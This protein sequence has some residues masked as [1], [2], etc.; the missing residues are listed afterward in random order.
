MSLKKTLL[1]ISALLFLLFIFFSFLVAKEKFTSLDFDTTVKIQDRLPRK[2]DLPFSYLS[3]IG[4]VEV[5]GLFMFGLLSFM[6]LKRY[7][8]TAA[9]LFLLPFALAMEVFGKA[10]V[11][12]PGPPIF[13]YRGVLQFDFLPKYYVPHEYSYPSGHML[14]MSF[15]LSFFAVWSLLK[16]SHHHR[17][18]AYLF[19]GGFLVAMAVSR[20]YLGEHWVS[21][22]IGGALIGTSFGILT[23]ITIPSPKNKQFNILKSQTEEVKRTEPGS[24]QPDHIK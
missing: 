17:L 16:L 20:V 4:S 23:G 18:I 10:F 8:L 3:V 9:A 19:L 22:V 11:Y 6:L 7:W 14:R 5:T 15:I 24:Y 12:H 2:V 1:L 21:D 13:L